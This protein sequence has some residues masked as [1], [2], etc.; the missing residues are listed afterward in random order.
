MTARQLI[1]LLCRTVL[2][3]AGL[4]VFL[5]GCTRLGDSPV[6]PANDGR[7]LVPVNLSLAV[8]PTEEGMPGTKADYEPDYWGAIADEGEKAAAIAASIQTIAI[9]QFEKDEVGDGYTRVGNQISYAWPLAAGE[10]IALVTSNRENIIFVIANATAPGEQTIPLAG[11]TTLSSFLESQN[12]NLISSLDALDG[13]GIWYSPDGT[14]AN[15]YLRMSVTKV[16]P[17][18]TLGTVLEESA[19]VP[20][21]L[22]QNCAKVVINVKNSCLSG[23]AD[24]VDIESVQLCDINQNYHF[25][26]NYTGFIDPYSPMSPRRFDDEEKAFPAA[27]NPDGASHGTA[28]TYTFYV[29]ANMRGTVENDAQIDK[30][31]HAPQGATYFRVYA[32]SGGKPVTYTYYLGGNLTDDFNLTANKKYEFTIDIAG[33]GDP[34]TDSRVENVSEVKFNVDA[35]CYMLKPPTRSGTA[36][37]Y[38]IPVAR[39]AVFWNPRGT[40]LGV[41]GAS[42]L[43]DNVNPLTETTAWTASFVWNKIFDPAVSLIEPVADNDLLVDASGTGFN[44]AVNDDAF[45]RIRIGAGMKGNALVAVKNAAGHILWSWH[46]WVTDY[47]PYVNVTPVAGNYL[48]AVPNGE[49]H[50]YGGDTWTSAAYAKAFIMDR[51]LGA[52]SAAPDGDDIVPTCGFFYENGRKDPFQNA[53]SVPAI[54]SSNTDQPADANGTKYNIRYSIHH[55]DTFI[56]GDWTAFEKGEITLGAKGAV[57]YDPR[58]DQHGADNC[59]AGKSIYDPCPPGWQVPVYGVWSDFSDSTK[60]VLTPHTAVYYY[61]E[62]YDPLAPKGR[63]FY[64]FAGCRRGGSIEARN[65]VCAMKTTVSGLNITTFNSGYQVANATTAVPVRCIRLSHKLPY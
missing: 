19:G 15:R 45:I 16:V 59:E 58:T 17:E 24:R 25:L 28:E 20:L 14:G 5:P 44:S 41:Y 29:P 62:G 46:L 35:N 32:T 3:S 42:A 65:V 54:A 51:N 30:N 47:D 9:L 1:S 49:I 8:A 2:L 48:Y 18:V 52:T 40:E 22:N 13:T 57:W 55:P 27:K 64:P 7:E 21:K 50:R 38:S 33:R 4:L 31:R 36:T 56:T 61:P 10:N 43:D 53:G 26:T 6:G 11:N 34:E 37:T 60:E 23:A 63:V 12:G 39:A